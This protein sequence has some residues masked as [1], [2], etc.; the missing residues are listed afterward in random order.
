MKP[1]WA[2]SYNRLVRIHESFAF[3]SLPVTKPLRMEI[4]GPVTVSTEPAQDDLVV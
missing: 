3:K 2:I 1:A 4:T